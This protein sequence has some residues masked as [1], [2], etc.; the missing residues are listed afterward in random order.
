MGH[1]CGVFDSWTIESETVSYKKCDKS[2]FDYNG[3][4]VPADIRWFFDAEALEQS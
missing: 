3:S 1:K 4:G 2:F